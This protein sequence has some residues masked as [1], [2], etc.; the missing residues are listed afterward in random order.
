MADLIVPGAGV[1][2]ISFADGQGGGITSYFNYPEHFDDNFIT[3][4]N[5]I[6]TLHERVTAVGGP[7][8]LIPLRVAG[9]N[10]AN[11][12]QSWPPGNTDVEVG[13]GFVGDHSYVVTVGTPT[14][15]ADITKGQLI[16]GG[17]FCEQSAGVTLSGIGISGA[18]PQDHYFS[19]DLNGV[20]S[21][22]DSQSARDFA[23]LFWNGT[24]YTGTWTRLYPVLFDGDA[25]RR[26]QER[27]SGLSLASVLYERADLRILALE[28]MLSGYDDDS[29]GNA[30]GPILVDFGGVGDPQLCMGAA[31]T[32]DSLGWYRPASNQWGLTTGAALVLLL[33]ATGIQMSLNGSA[34][35]PTVRL[36]SATAGLYNDGTGPAVSH[37]SAR[38]MRWDAGA[39][40]FE[41]GTGP[42][43]GVTPVGD[44]NSGLW[45]PGADI[46]ALSTAGNECFRAT[47]AG[48][49]N[50][51]LNPAVSHSV[52]AATITQGSLTAV[53]FTGVAGDDVGDWHE[54]VTNPDRFTCP[55]DGHYEISAMFTFDESAVGGGGVADAG[56]KRN[57]AITL[58]GSTI[59]KQDPREPFTSSASTGDPVIDLHVT[60]RN[61]SATDIIRF[62]VEHD[63]GGTMDVDVEIAI[64]KVG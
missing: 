64:Q 20:V 34:A 4:M 8:A 40:R 19:V 7:N 18:T 24:N 13:D 62:A 31:G 37:G 50:F 22:S 36:N 29:L 58:N 5:A 3:L 59:L 16:L 23:T 11:G 15:N 44:P 38:C 39:A 32:P 26:M 35:T 49:L 2:Y 48:A 43:P 45:S 63:N 17:Q 51:D 60:V 54:N 61:L 28:R 12:P 21:V 14:T 27:P 56:S 41:A 55:A 6:N 47:A 46:L 52:A 42:L 25:Y 9:L 30:V 33:T 57:A 10:D 53:S 1:Y